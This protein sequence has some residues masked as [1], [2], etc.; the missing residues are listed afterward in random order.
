MSKFTTPVTPGLFKSRSQIPIDLMV[1]P[2]VNNLK[3]IMDVIDTP[4]QIQ[5]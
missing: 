1:P 3:D 2:P 5:I 4:I